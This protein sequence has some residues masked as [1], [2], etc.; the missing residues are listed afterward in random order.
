MENFTDSELIENYLKGDEQALEILFSRYLKPVYSFVLKV[1]GNA[2][3]AEDITQNAFIK[4]WKNLKKFNK[5]KK[6]KPWIFQI[7]KN[8]SLDYLRKKKAI[9]MSEFENEEGDNILLQT[10]ADPDPLPSEIFDRSNLAVEAGAVIKELPLKDRLILNLYFDNDFTFQEI[11]D[12]TSEPLNTV[13]SRQRRA[14]GK[15]R[16]KLMHQN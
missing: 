9:A 1:A 12:L 14:L 3:E 7:A 15:L 6:F 2:E 11:A 10:L 8:T 16:K 13:K 4:A 5:G